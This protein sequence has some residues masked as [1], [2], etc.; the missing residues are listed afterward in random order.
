MP[1]YKE[2]DD[3]EFWEHYWKRV[4]DEYR[5]KTIRNE[6]LDAVDLV[7]LCRQLV[8]ARGESFQN[9]LDE[10]KKWLQETRESYK[11]EFGTYPDE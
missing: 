2:P 6:Y 10:N 4:S 9:L 7:E 8:E 5:R 11:K 3:V 1:S